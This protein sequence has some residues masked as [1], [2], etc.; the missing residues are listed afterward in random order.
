MDDEN[1]LYLV[2]SN[3][4]RAW[5]RSNLL[6]YS[7]GFAE[8]GRYSRQEALDICRQAILSAPHVGTIAEIPVR[9]ADVVSFLDGQKVPREITLG[10]PRHSDVEE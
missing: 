2:W 8:A 1:D 10:A 4:H 6:G 5:W 7:T 3:E 9:L